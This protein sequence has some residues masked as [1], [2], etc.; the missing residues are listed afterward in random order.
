MSL[1][2]SSEMMSNQSKVVRDTVRMKENLREKLH[3]DSKVCNC[4]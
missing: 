4:K 1:I 2:L 3:D